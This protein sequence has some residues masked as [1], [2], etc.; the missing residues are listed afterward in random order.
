MKWKEVRES[1]PNQFVKL[2][3]LESHVEG[4]KK[5]IDEMAVIKLIYD[6][7]EATK[8]LVNSKDDVIVY[9]TGNEKIVIEIRNIKGYRGVLSWN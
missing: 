5:Y 7:K 1:Y 2:K 3:I 8:E 6:N 4:N 9:H